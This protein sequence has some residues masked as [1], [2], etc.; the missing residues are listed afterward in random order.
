M[1]ESKLNFKNN[2]DYKREK[3]LCDSCESAVDDNTHV[4]YCPSYQDLRAGLRLEDDSDLAWY[5][6]KVLAIRSRL[7]LSR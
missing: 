3:Y 6:H 1:Y 2:P 4:I 5:L 7:R